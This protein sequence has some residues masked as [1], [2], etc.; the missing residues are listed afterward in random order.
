MKLTDIKNVFISGASKGIGF[1]YAIRFLEN[2]IRVV[3]VAKNMKPL[4]DYATENNKLDLL[5]ALEFDLTSAK[6]IDAVIKSIDKIDFDVMINNAGFGY[7]G[8][9]LETDVEREMSLIDLNIKSLHKMTKYFYQKYIDSTSKKRIINIASIAAFMPGPYHAAYFASKSY[10][11]SLSEAIGFEL[12]KAKS[13]LSVI[14]VC[15]GSIKTDFW[16]T[17]EYTNKKLPGAAMTVEKLANLS[18]KKMLKSKKAHIIIGAK[19]RMTVSTS[20]CAPLNVKLGL[21]YKLNKIN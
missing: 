14:A 16:K 17:S 10:V 2:N 18:F 21:T 9:F 13:N 19:N 8:N 12:K 6:D 7:A 5:T 20:K 11:L 4:I 1:Q 3:G 15:P